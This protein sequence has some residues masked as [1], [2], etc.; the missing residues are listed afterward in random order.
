MSIQW[1]QSLQTGNAQIDASQKV[2]FELTNQLIA[3]DDWM[4]L[5]PIM[6]ALYKQMTSHFALEDALMWEVAYPATKAHIEQHQALLGRLDDRSMDVGKGRLNKNAVVAVMTDWAQGHV[7]V[8][9]A[10][11]ARFLKPSA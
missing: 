7:T 9:D 5:R 8:D 2:L 3:S 10:E 6:V 4:V 1:D 11:L